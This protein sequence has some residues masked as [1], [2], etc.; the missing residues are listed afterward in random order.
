MAITLLFIAC[1]FIGAIILFG[2]LTA[3]SATKTGE[4][5]LAA[6]SPNQRKIKACIAH[7]ELVDTDESKDLA[8]KLKAKLKAI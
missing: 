6:Q 1:F 4:R 7:L 8:K 5:L 2:R 3:G